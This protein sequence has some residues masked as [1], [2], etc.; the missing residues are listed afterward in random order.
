MKKS[1]FL[2]SFLCIST[3]L[4][5]QIKT[6]T[7]STRTTNQKIVGEVPLAPAPES[8]P[9]PAPAPVNKST[10]P[11]TETA[12]APSAYKLISTRVSIK[13]GADNKEF[14]SEV[15]MWLR[16]TNC[17]LCMEQQMGNLRNEMKINSTTEIGLEKNNRGNPESWTLE[18]FQNG[19]FSLSIVYFPNLLTDAWKIE[20]VSMVLLFESQ[21]GGQISKSLTFNNASGFLDGFN[22]NL[23][24]KADGKF[25]PT[26]SSIKP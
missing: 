5:A 24:C 26:T 13:T 20:G 14:P 25:I 21:D 6:Y 1:L 11:G 18:C 22:H 12:P 15:T 4:L 2:L 19:G 9:A 23:E 16:A 3:L 8:A 10:V 17:G 7:K